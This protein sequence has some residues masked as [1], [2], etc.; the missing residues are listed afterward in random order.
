MKTM[1]RFFTFIIIL[2]TLSG[3]FA[4]KEIQQIVDANKK[5]CPQV[6]EILKC[7][8]IETDGTLSDIVAKTQAAWLRKPGSERWEMDALVTQNDAKLKEL[9][10]EIKMFDEIKPQQKHYTHLLILGAVFNTMQQRLQHA[11]EL[12]KSGINFDNIVFLAGARPCVADQGE[13]LETFLKY[14]SSEG[15]NKIPETEAEMLQFIYSHA[16]MPEKMR[17]IPTQMINVPMQT[18]NSGK[19]IRPTTADTLIWWM[20]TN[21]KSG[22]CLAISNQPYVAYQQSVITSFVPNNFDVETVGGAC[23]ETKELAIMLDTLARI[24]YQEQQRL[25]KKS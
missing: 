20:Q 9:L 22:N 25:E 15:L 4:T 16:N 3:C 7:T 14:S 1:H 10:H 24:L 13:N 8:G 2:S 11:I 23:P 19:L 17:H 21:P 6:F 18:S 5:V 12:Y